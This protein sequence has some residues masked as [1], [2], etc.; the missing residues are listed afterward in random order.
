M[1]LDPV[2]YFSFI[3]HEVLHIDDVQAYIHYEIEET[4]SEDILD[5]YTENIMDE[6]GNPKPKF[7]QLQ[8]KGFT[9]FVNFSTFD[10]K[11]WVR[12]VLR[13]IHA[14]F[15][16]LDQ[17]YKITADAIKEVTCLNQTSDKP[18]L[19]KVTNPTVNKLTDAE[20]D[21]WSMKINIIK[22]ADVKFAA[23]VIGY[24]VY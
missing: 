11:E 19:R 15:I 4:D 23:M 18:G 24:K 5:L 22:E 6:I 12:Y 7:A 3:L 13:R 20:F 10:E 14:E 9:Q 17:P 8:R 1:E 21:G 2:G 16:W